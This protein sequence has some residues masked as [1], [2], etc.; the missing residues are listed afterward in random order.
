[1]RRMSAAAL[2]ALGL[3]LALSAC[4]EGPEQIYTPN[5]PELDPAVLNGHGASGVRAPGTQPFAYT[6]SGTASGTTKICEA[7]EL[8]KR[9]SKMVKQPIVPGVGAGGLDLRGKNWAG[10]TVDE[11]QQ[12]LCQAYIY[13]SGMVYWGDNAELIAFHDTKNRLIDRLVT[14]TGYEGTIKAGDYEIANNKPITFKGKK[15]ENAD[16]DAN[17]RKMNIAM[18]KAFK[19]SFKN[20]DQRDCVKANTCYVMDW[21][22]LKRF[23]FNDLDLDFAVEPEADKIDHIGVNL[24]R[25]FDLT[26][27]DVKFEMTPA[28]ATGHPPMPVIAKDSSCKPTLGMTWKHVTDHCMGTDPPEKAL[29]RPVWSNEALLTD[30]GGLAFYLERPSLKFDEIIPDD[31]KAKATDKI[32]AMYFNTT[33]E[34]KFL[35]DRAQL[36]SAFYTRVAAAVTA[37]VPTVDVTTLLANI[38]PVGDATKIQLG[39]QKVDNC[40]GTGGTCTQSTL[41]IAVRKVVTD[42]VKAKAGAVPDQL[43]DP[44]F[45]VEHLL[46]EFIKQ[47]N[48]GNEPSATDFYMFPADDS[49]QVLYATL[50]RTIGGKRYAVKT[51]YHNKSDQ[52]LYLFFKQG[53]MR[54]EGVLFQDAELTSTDGV[55]RLWNLVKSPR[56]GMAKLFFPKKT[57]PKI[58]KALL[59]INMAGVKKQVMVNYHKQDSLS[60]YSIPIEGDRDKFVSASYYGFSGNVVGAGFWASHKD[61]IITAISSG[62]FYDKLDFCGVKVGL[63]DEVPPLLKKL[64]ST[65]EKII[66]YSENGKIMTAISTYVQKTPYKIGLRLWVTADRVDG[67]YYWAEQ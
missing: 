62:A 30:M 33:Y 26:K 5:P 56:M 12:K 22:T 14:L 32:V 45:Y 13:S 9:W 8:A 11:A 42:E 20:P 64:P 28:P 2:V 50:L 18:L 35:V 63:Y 31:T 60:G 57:Y 55:F 41:T 53:A 59:E 44:N 65:C 19:K 54:T 67:A 21:Y 15:L 61:G 27:S 29:A 10:L 7:D 47:F 46:R 51:A 52:L 4:E 6:T 40:N 48:E 3:A 17:I 37:L 39:T 16:S 25:T 24:R 58:R 36:Y 23:V 43:L 49:A 38:K 1:M 66:S 34:G